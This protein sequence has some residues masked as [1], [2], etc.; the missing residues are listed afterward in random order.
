MVPEKGAPRATLSRCIRPNRR[1][2]SNHAPPSLSRERN[3]VSARPCDISSSLK[4]TKTPSPTRESRKAT[5]NCDQSVLTR[6]TN[7]TMTIRT[8]ATTDHPTRRAAA[9]E[10]CG[11]PPAQ[12]CRRDDEEQ[13]ADIDREDRPL[14]VASA[15]SPISGY[16]TPPSLVMR[17]MVAQ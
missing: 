11:P 10:E 9:L 17:T 14:K 8:G 7:A 6:L 16:G 15:D 3:A 12:R 13:G 4:P 2:L 1:L 5:S